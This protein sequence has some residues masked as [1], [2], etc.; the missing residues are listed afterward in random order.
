MPRLGPLERAVMDA[1]W[2]TTTTAPSAP[3]ARDLRH[4]VPKLAY[5]TV[6]TVLDRL[7]DKGFL[8]RVSNDRPHRYRPTGSQASYVAELMHEALAMTRC[9]MRALA[10]FVETATPDQLVA[11]SSGLAG[12]TRRVGRR[13]SSISLR[14]REEVLI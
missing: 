13:G 10:A 4:A 6:I 3:A 1:M 12:R 11:L 2:A 8:E 9:P 5:T 14:E 7:V